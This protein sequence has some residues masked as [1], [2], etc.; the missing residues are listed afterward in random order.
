MYCSG[1]YTDL[2]LYDMRDGTL[3]PEISTQYGGF[4]IRVMPDFDGRGA[5]L[6]VDGMWADG[7]TAFGATV[8]I[9]Y[10]PMCGRMLDG[11]RHG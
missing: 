9:N 6:D 4:G 11:E 2:P 1:R 10:C 8:P 7:L 5:Y 3:A